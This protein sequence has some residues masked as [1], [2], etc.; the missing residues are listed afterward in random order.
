MQPL[1]ALTFDCNKRK[2]YSTWLFLINVYFIV[3][4]II[5][6]FENNYYTDSVATPLEV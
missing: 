5:E 3:V 2:I 6:T 4:N 1:I